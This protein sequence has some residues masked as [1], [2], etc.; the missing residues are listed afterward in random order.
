[1]ITTS[2]GKKAIKV[3]QLAL[4]AYHKT[5]SRKSREDQIKDIGIKIDN[6]L[7]FIYGYTDINDPSIHT[8]DEI[9]N[10][11]F[12]D[13]ADD[14]NA[15]NWNVACGFYKAAASSLRNSLDMAVAALYFQIREN[16]EMG[17]GAYNKYFAEWDNG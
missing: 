5:I 10:W 13:V 9:I 16:T 14:L 15:A 17:T 1:M 2:M 7:T 8:D 12:V 3:C 11:T 4:R 6:L